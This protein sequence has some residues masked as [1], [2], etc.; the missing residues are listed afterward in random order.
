MRLLGFSG[1]LGQLRLVVLRKLLEVVEQVTTQH[2][3]FVAGDRGCGNKV[4]RGD[5][6]GHAVIRGEVRSAQLLDLVVKPFFLLRACSR[7]A[8]IGFFFGFDQC[9]GVGHALVVVGQLGRVALVAQL[10]LLEGAE[11]AQLRAHFAQVLHGR[12][13]VGAGLFNLC[14]GDIQPPHRKQAQQQ[15]EQSG[16]T[17]SHQ[18]LP[19]N[20]Q[21]LEPFH[22]RRLHWHCAVRTGPVHL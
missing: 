6:G 2:A 17:E 12:H 16:G 14:F 4:I 7:D 21:V 20:R 8:V 22:C 15:G 13:P 19:C 11:F 9:A 10:R 3:R 1:L 18:Q 5:G